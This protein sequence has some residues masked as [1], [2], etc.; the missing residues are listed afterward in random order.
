MLTTGSGIDDL[1]DSRE[2]EVV[3]R[4]IIVEHSEVDTHSVDLGILLL[5]HD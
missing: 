3:L 1:V 5:N 4:A 2:Q